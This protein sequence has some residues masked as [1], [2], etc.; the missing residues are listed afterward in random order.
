MGACLTAPL[1]AWSYAGWKLL[2][3]PFLP[4]DLFDWITRSLPGSIVTLAIDA[5]I[6]AGQLWRWG[7]LAAAAKTVEQTMAIVLLLAG[8]VAGGTVL[9]GLLRL[10]EEPAGLLGVILGFAAGFMALLIEQNLN[11]IP[12]G[13]I[14]PGVW[15]VSTC[16]I[17]GGAFG[18]VYNRLSAPRDLEPHG[19]AFDRVRRRLLMGLGT[20]AVLCSA[21]GTLLA[22]LVGRR[23]EGVGERWSWSHPLPNAASEIAPAPGTRRE[24]TPLEDHYRIDINTRAPVLDGGR[25]RLQIAGLVNRPLALSLDDLRAEAPTHQMVTLEC[26]SDPIGGDLIGT[27]RWTGVSLQRL[28]T[29]VGVAKNA[30]HLR[31]S[32]ADGFFETVPLETINQDS[33]V[34]LAYAWDGLP[35]AVEHGF[36]LRIYIPSVYGMKQPKWIAAI[37]AID[38]F[39]AGYWVSRGWDREGRVKIESVVDSVKTGA[40]A[41][42]GTRLTSVGGYAY[43]GGR[44]VSKVE[45]QIDGGGWRAA[46]IREPLSDTTWVLWRL[47]LPLAAGEH[48]FVVRC[49]SGDAAPQPGPLHS[50][51]ATIA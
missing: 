10:S 19:V 47:D 12:T 13:S 3:L 30:T 4:F 31:I 5:I 49:E 6:K 46:R 16:V 32:S 42:D 7:S 28:L 26:I 44:G 8:G 23:R 43:S 35:L 14:L 15:V 38:H 50:R 45:V 18:Y 29:R 20:A 39:E 22:A 33:R 36:P 25:W 40:A 34:M 27:T 17:W 48:I 21:A 37:D 11:R 1:I 41:P 24:F 51:R 9:F 2:G